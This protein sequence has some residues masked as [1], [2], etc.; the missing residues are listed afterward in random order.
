ME[1]TLSEEELLYIGLDAGAT[2]TELLACVSLERDRL[3]LSGPAAN[4]QRLGFDDSARI[5]ARLIQEAIQMR[6]V[7]ALQAVCAGV[8]GAG[9]SE[10]QQTL[11][12]KIRQILGALAP[13]VISVVHDGEI[14]L[15]AAF[16]GDSGVIVIAGTGSVV[17][18]RSVDGAML[19]A[20][21]W[22]YLL[23]DE[24]SGYILGLNGLRAVA[25][26]LDGGPSTQ[27]QDLLASR[28]NIKAA[29]E[30]I[31]HVYREQWAVQRMG[32]IVVEAA[33]E[34]DS[35]AQAILTQQ[36]RSLAE[37]VVWLLQRCGNIKPQIALM[38]GMTRAV[39]Y[40]ETL[41]QALLEVLPDW[42]VQSTPHQPV[43]GAWRL[44]AKAQ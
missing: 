37:Q 26:A 29:D 3:S 40:R 23:G 13:P 19:R 9:R 8:A 38:G 36:T 31:H 12:L 4:P 5:L 18:A 10:D 14:A 7:A 41:E 20:G 22:G 39:H 32:P 43:V 6:P 28:F 30:L 25:H 21:G 44:A 1:K 11:E 34:G 17:L 42:R 16:P 27:L 15:E 24:G 2:K 33:L 35:I